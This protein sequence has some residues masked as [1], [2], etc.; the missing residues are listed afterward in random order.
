[1][2]DLYPAQ[3]YANYGSY[4][5]PPYVSP[6]WQAARA[7][8]PA[9]AGAVNAA[10]Q[11]AQFLTVHGIVPLYA[12]NR[13]WTAA[14]VSGTPSAGNF[15][16]LPPSSIGG[17]GALPLHD[18]DQPFTMPFGSN[19]VGRVQVP[20]LAAGN[21]ADLQVT[22][23]PDNG[24]GA[25]RTSSPA[26]QA[27]VPAAHIT[28][29]SAPSGLAAAGPL[30]LSRYNTAC[31]GTAFATT[32][33]QP[34]VSANGAGNYATPV[35]SGNWTLFVGGADG[36][37]LAAI[38]GVSAVQY[39]GG[40][41]VSGAI[42]QPPLPQA[43]S[44][45]CAAATPDT[46]VVAGGFSGSTAFANVWTAPWAPGTG[47]VG[48][49]SAQQALPQPAVCAGMAA[50]NDTVYLA[51]GAT[52]T[53]GASTASPAV[54][55]AQVSNG[56]ISA[57]VTCQSLPRGLYRP[58]CAVIGNWLVITGGTDSSGTFLA[59]TWIAGINPDG[60]LQSWAPGPPLPEP[61]AA[62]VPGWNQATA[63]NVLLIISGLNSNTPTASACTQILS[64][65]AD[66]PAPQ[67]QLQDWGD[68]AGTFQCAAYPS[69]LAGNWEA[70]TFQLTSYQLGLL[71]PVPMVPVPLAASG[72]V[73]G[74]TYHLVFH[75][76]GGDAAVNYLQLGEM[77]SSG[78]A[79]W[80]Y[81]APG[82][83]GPWTAHAGHV[84][85]ADIYDQSPSGPLMHLLDDSGARAV[86][87]AYG[88]STGQLL[89]V[90]EATA[91]PPGSPAAMLPAVTQVTYSSG[92]PS[93]L[94][95]LA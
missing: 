56:Q 48:A 31:L 11:V 75:Q 37:T 43:A 85:P 34:A 64:F 55:R 66:G 39:L 41:A 28:A 67:W 65:T 62:F 3:Y 80:L 44:T 2:S 60:S 21:G 63:G 93:G 74:S 76:A 73:A 94:A 89:G 82:S 87:L 15:F 14:S 52:A 53:G 26:A 84:I 29:L 54:Y 22:L 68:V 70:F 88:S 27:T 19:Q 40:S 59:E 78:L 38:T 95:Q 4:P 5:S 47:T 32:W 72:L 83:G 10:V 46:I 51:C 50:W 23:Y 81:S 36:V 91:F 49:W 12:G 9:D 92:Q 18:V 45:V 30:A 25:P 1:M 58:F 86:T 6:Y 33:S 7:G 71:Q 42:P 90:L 79:P 16:W 17:I 20:V 57:W 69:G 61:A 8:M 77:A 24:S 13:I 35:T